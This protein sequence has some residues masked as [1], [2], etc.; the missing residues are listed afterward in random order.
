MR[1]LLDN[2]GR[3]IDVGDMVVAVL[4]ELLLEAAVAAAQVEN[5]GVFALRHAELQLLLGWGRITLRRG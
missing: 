2:D 1:H 4:V 3:D 5:A